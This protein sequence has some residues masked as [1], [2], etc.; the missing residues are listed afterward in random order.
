MARTLTNLI[1]A[2]ED[3]KIPFTQID[4]EDTTAPDM[5]YIILMPGDTD[6]WFADGRVNETPVMYLVE[7]YTRV[8]DVPLEVE[9]QTALNDAGIGWQRA[10]V[11]ISD[12]R[13]IMTRWYTHV[14]ER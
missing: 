8:R 13:G 1:S 7:L 5:P 2:L 3:T 12:G 14:F 9:V 6:N 4:W 11:P 10:T